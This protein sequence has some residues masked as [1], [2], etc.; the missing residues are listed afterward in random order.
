[1]HKNSEQKE[2]KLYEKTTNKTNCELNKVGKIIIIGCMYVCG[3]SC[4]YFYLLDI[5]W[6]ATAFLLNNK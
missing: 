2:S 3:L 6:P 4:N 5:L 1:M